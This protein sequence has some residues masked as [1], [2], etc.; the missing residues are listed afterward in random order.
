MARY[1]L[2]ILHREKVLKQLIIEFSSLHIT[3]FFFLFLYIIRFRLIFEFS[4]NNY[5]KI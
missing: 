4:I 3:Q 1:N 2:L 5:I